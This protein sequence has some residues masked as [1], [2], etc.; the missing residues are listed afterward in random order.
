MCLLDGAGHVECWGLVSTYVNAGVPTGLKLVGVSQISGS[1]SVATG[2]YHTCAIQNSGQVKCW[3]WNFYG[4]IITP[5]DLGPVTQISTG[6]YHTCA[7]TVAGVVRCWGANNAG[8]SDVPSDLGPATA[9]A[10]GDSHTCAITSSKNVRCWGSNDYGQLNVPTDLG[11]VSQITSG[12]THACALTVVDTVRCWGNNSNSEIS[13]PGTLGEALEVKVGGFHTCAISSEKK[14]LCWGWNYFGQTDVPSDLGSVRSISTGLYDTCAVTLNGTARCWGY[15]GQGQTD[16]PEN[17]GEVSQISAGGFHTCAI[18]ISKNLKCWGFNEYGQTQIPSDLRL[19]P[20]LD[21]TTMPTINGKPNLGVELEANV[22]DWDSGVTFSYNWLRDGVEING[23]T[24]SKYMSIP[25]DVGHA[26]SV[27]VIG[28]LDGYESTSLVSQPV[29]IATPLSEMGSKNW[30]R[31]AS[32]SDGTKLAAI[33]GD[34]TIWTSSDSGLNWI[35]RTGAG[36]TFTGEVLPSGTRS[37]QRVA[38]SSDG[39]KLAAVVYNGSVWTS[40]D[41]GETWIER[42]ASGARFWS[43]IASSADGTKLVALAYPGG[44]WTSTDSGLTW[45]ERTNAGYRNWGAVAS[46]ADGTVI[47]ASWNDGSISVS[48]DS[49]LN[50]SVSSIPSNFGWWRALASNADG[51][52]LYG[53]EWCGGVWESKDSGSSWARNESFPTK[54]WY[55]I[56]V[57]A[58]GSKIIAG[59]WAAEC[60]GTPTDGKISLATSLNKFTQTGSATIQG[61]G[62]VGSVV[63]AQV[64]TYPTGTSFSYQWLRDGISVSGATDSQFVIRDQDYG[65]NISYQLTVTKSG[66]ESSN[67][68]SSSLEINKKGLTRLSSLVVSGKSAVGRVLSASIS[69]S[70]GLSYSYQ[71]LRDGVPIE[72]AVTRKYVLTASDANTTIAFRVCGTKQEFET[73]CLVSNSSQ[74]ALGE[75]SRRPYVVMKW[76]AA[77]VGATIQGR[78]GNW[79]SDV[80]L[81]CS[82]LRDGALIPGENQGTYQISVADRGHSI[83]FKVKAQKTGYYEVARVSASKFIR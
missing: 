54:T 55:S 48:H 14:V 2:N 26:L 46:N 23:A 73:A 13:V 1:P 20:E 29:T 33:A 12:A 18:T 11:Q 57:N 76:A 39:T 60:W 24:K 51:T 38:S 80:S 45:T 40:S 21:L 36:I 63:K 78:P 30:P 7:V 28:S 22:G 27:R 72:G 19:L 83:T 68:T 79:D 35:Q 4:Q 50:W 52:R 41:S 65:H 62:Y 37:W 67:L 69:R 75:M 74:V 5:G 6:Q 64:G 47:V 66:Y 49:G 56:A 9:V 58:D 43:D 71:W 81:S 16:I 44:V 3:G 77:K 59:S 25:S 82:W 61:G 42:P 32:N 10:A 17:L 34:H 53:V 70:S 15:N 31:V 8:R